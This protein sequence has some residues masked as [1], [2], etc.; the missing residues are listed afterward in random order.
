M[1]LKNSVVTLH[2][3]TKPEMFAKLIGDTQMTGRLL[4][5]LQ[6]LMVMMNKD[7]IGDELICHK[8]IL[9]LPPLNNPHNSSREK[10]LPNGGGYIS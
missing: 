8:F 3:R 6:E 9:M 10:D 4:I 2:E 7:G 1:E 5:Y